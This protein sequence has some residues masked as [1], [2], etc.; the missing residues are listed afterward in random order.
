MEKYFSKRPRSS[1]E[2]HSVDQP[3]QTLDENILNKNVEVEINPDEVEINENDI[4][5]DPGLRP[6]IHSFNINIRD[7]IRREYIFKGPCQPY[8]HNFPKK[9]YGKDNRGFR[10]VW[11]KEFDW[12]EYSVSKDAAF[13]F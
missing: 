4:V 12:L 7:C 6:P 2:S 10:D 5:A 9:K 13:C 1:V 3:P 8:G 11:F